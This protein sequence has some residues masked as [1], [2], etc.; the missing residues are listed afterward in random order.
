MN[1]YNLQKFQNLSLK[2]KLN[3]KEKLAL[4]LCYEFVEILNREIL[5][6]R[7]GIRPP[8]NTTPR[9][10]ELFRHA[11]KLVNETEKKLNPEELIHFLGAQVNIFKRIGGVNCDVPVITSAVIS[12]EKAWKR[13]IAWKHICKEELY[14]QNY[15]LNA[16]ESNS[17]Q[18]VIKGLRATKSLLE[19][20]LGGLEAKLVIQ[21][22][23]SRAIYK[24]F[25]LRVI[26]P[27]YMLLSPLV[28]EKNL[29]GMQKF[30]AG[31]TEEVKSWFRT[32]FA[33]EFI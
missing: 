2:Y 19:R 15:H 29:D 20:K 28:K 7:H 24:W 30:Q 9:K 17:N 12:G 23:K 3:E 25:A 10:N 16:L 1:S 6:Y 31:I 18:N 33:H 21:A 5:N 14:L 32:E 22:E 26:S 11:Y 8:N 4:N 27:Y 13:W